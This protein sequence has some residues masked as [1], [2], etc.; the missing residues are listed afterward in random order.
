MEKKIKVTLDGVTREVPWGIS[1]ADLL[2]EDAGEQKKT[3]TVLAVADGKL[4]EL[5]KSIR[6]DCTIER[7]GPDHPVGKQTRSR[8]TCMVLFKP[9][10]MCWGRRA[11][12]SSTLRYRMAT[13]LP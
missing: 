11:G 7:I 3:D 10:M 2:K 4:Q 12:L 9:Y 5:Y 8:T 13:I 6:R 1:F